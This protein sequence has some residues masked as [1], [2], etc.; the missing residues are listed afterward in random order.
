MNF[1][2]N[3]DQT[4]FAATARQFADQELAPFAAKWDREHYYSKSR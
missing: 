4:A 2:L 1:E 3:E